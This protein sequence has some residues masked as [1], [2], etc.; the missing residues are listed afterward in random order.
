MM[1]KESATLLVSRQA[2]FEEVVQALVKKLPSISPEV[3]DRI[4]LFDIRGHRE[5]REFQPTQA[6]STASIDPSYG[7]SLFAEPIPVEEDEAGDHDRFI[8]V[9]HFSK[10]VSRLHGI[11]LKFVIKPV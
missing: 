11:P 4:R 5:Y 9:V 6:I 7:T 3:Y 10:D 1:A 8:I 2:T